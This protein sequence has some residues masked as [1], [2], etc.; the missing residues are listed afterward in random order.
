MEEASQP[1]L[2]PKESLGPTWTEP[3]VTIN[4]EDTMHTEETISESLVNVGREEAVLEQPISAD[5]EDSEIS[6]EAEVSH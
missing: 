5:A 3:P 1:E 4:Q 6:W 2:E